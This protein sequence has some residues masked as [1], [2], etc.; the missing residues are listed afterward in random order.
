VATRNSPWTTEPGLLKELVTKLRLAYRL[1]REPSVPALT[2]LVPVIG[3][4]YLVWPIDL[5]PDI[6]PILGQLDD[7]GIAVAAIEIFLR[8]CPPAAA[9]F[10][11]DAIVHGRPYSPMPGDGSVI[12][13][14]YRRS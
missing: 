11:R 6:F 9:A 10:H 12:D 1:L 7:L 8:L 13:A 14:Q 3:A 4:V 2:K 5:L